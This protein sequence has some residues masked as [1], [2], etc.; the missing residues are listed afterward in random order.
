MATAA[1]NY[2]DVDD[3][4][5]EV[6]AELNGEVG[7]EVDGND[8]NRLPA[9]TDLQQ[10]SISGDA[11]LT[12]AEGDCEKQRANTEP[13]PIRVIT[14]WRWVLIIFSILSS[15][16][17]F[18]LDNTIVADI[19]PVIVLE[20]QSISKITWLSASF[21][22]GAASTNLIWGKVYA[23]FDAK[24]T[25]ILCV[26]MFEVGSAICGAAPNI[27]TMIIGRAVCGVGGSGMYVGVMTLLA[28]TTTI[29]ERPIYIGSTGLTWGLGTVLGPIIGG[30]FTVSSASW[31]WAFYIN[32]C[33]GAACAPIYIFIIPSCNPRPGVSFLNRAREMDYVGGTL[34]VGAFVSGV[35]AISFGG[36]EYPWSSAKIIAMFV[37]SATLFI[38]LG[39]QQA[40]CILTTKERRV[41]PVEFFSSRTILTVFACT[42]AGGAATFTPIYMIPIFFQFTRSDTALQAGVRLLPYIFILIL[43]I[44]VNGGVLS[45]YGL[46]M[47]W[48]TAGG[49][50]TII[51]G[52]LMY[53]ITSSTSVASVYGYSILLGWGNGLFVQSGFSIAQAVVEQHLVPLAIGFITCA[54]VS[55]ITIAL[56]IANSIFL[57]KAEKSLTAILPGTSRGQID[58]AIAGAGSAFVAD[59]D[60]DLQQRVLGA[61]VDA[62]SP[63][64]SL[65]IVAGAVVLVMSMFMKREK[66][67]IAA[68][69]AG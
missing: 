17:L 18:A 22:I 47:P 14:G 21:L 11:S 1:Q 57:N 39:F 61:I 38:L 43:G 41:F 60:S 69:G 33:I 32:L 59:L 65:C 15:A 24:W 62:I 5:K 13:V 28:A 40:N 42:A 37:C 68:A 35:M 44:G 29:K 25:Y 3:N 66:L 63:V 27:D 30:A 52:S 16:F 9:S 53:T 49:I 23:Q 45:A 31:R 46:Y 26:S 2:P 7:P 36:V 48:Y 4:A 12:G 51:G 34:T 56:T 58:R 50:F 20:F 8:S 64:Y 55:G 67:F 6:Y 19:Q 54:Q 10:K